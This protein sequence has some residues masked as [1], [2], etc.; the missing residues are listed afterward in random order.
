VTNHVAVLRKKGFIAETSGKNRHVTPTRIVRS[1]VRAS[2]RIPLLGSIAAGVPIE[3]IENVE[4]WFEWDALGVTNER[5]D[6]FALRGE[7]Q[8]H[9]QPRHPRRRCGGGAAPVVRHAA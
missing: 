1:H 2:S 5:G 3:A 9:G 8:F 4:T 6:K 7:R